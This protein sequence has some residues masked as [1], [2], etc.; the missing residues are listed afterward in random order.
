MSRRFVVLV[1]LIA[2]KSSSVATDVS[3]PSATSA[4]PTPA[5]AAPGPSVAASTT[6]ATSSGVA[7]LD[8]SPAPSATTRPVMCRAC[9]RVHVGDTYPH[10]N[11][12][13]APH[14]DRDAKV[15][16]VDAAACTV[17]LK[18]VA[19]GSTRVERCDSSFFDEPRINPAG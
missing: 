19:S 7:D 14:H 10:Q 2:C 15:L 9:A 4:A 6:T 16:G 13:A 8:A 3:A 12:H 11:G 5:S 1:V 18:D 17:T